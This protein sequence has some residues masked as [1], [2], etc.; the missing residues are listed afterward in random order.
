MRKPRSRRCC[1]MF[2]NS[3]HNGVLFPV[4]SQVS[5]SPSPRSRCLKSLFCCVNKN[6][7]S[8]YKLAI[9]DVLAG[10]GGRGEE[11]VHDEVLEVSLKW[12][13]N[14]SR[15]VKLLLPASCNKNRCYAL[16]IMRH[17]QEF[18]TRILQLSHIPVTE[19]S[20]TDL[21]LV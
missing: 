20:Q 4:F 21:F 11:G 3:H 9:G 12:A 18:I 17:W 7:L 5:A 15:G 14:P 8:Q 19:F 13:G 6:H 10:G 1:L 16:D 2:G